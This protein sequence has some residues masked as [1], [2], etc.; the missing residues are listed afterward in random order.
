MAGVFFFFFF[1]F[2]FVFYFF[3]FFF[4]FFYR[5]G[6]QERGY[7]VVARPANSS[8]EQLGALQAAIFLAATAS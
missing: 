3:F 6:W 8:V 1:F 7:P 2:F 4:F 5:T